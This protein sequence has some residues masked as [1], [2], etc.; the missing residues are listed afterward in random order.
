MVEMP[1]SGARETA[2]TD[3]VAPFLWDDIPDTPDWR[4]RLM[5]PVSAASSRVMGEAVCREVIAGTAAVEGD[6]DRQVA[7]VGAGLFVNGFVSLAE[8]AYVAQAE[9]LS[10]ITVLGGPPELAAL[11]DSE[12]AVEVMAHRHRGKGIFDVTPANHP[13][14]RSVARTASW[15]PPLMLAPALMAPSSTAI[16][17]NALL[18]R[19]ARQKGSRTRYWPAA[20]ILVAVRGR[21]PEREDQNAGRALTRSMAE[22]LLPLAKGLEEPW[23]SRVAA[24]FEARVTPSIAKINADVKAIRKTRRLPANVWTGTGAAY[25]ARLIASEVSRRGGTVTGF[26]HGGVTAISQVLELTSISELMVASRFCVATRPWAQLLEHSKAMTLAAP[27]GGCEIIH[28]DGE[29]T[30]RQACLD[31]S[32]PARRRVVYVGHP[33]RALRQFAIA[34]TSDAIYWDLQSRLAAHL[35]ELSVDLICKPHPEGHFV[36]KRNPIEQIAPT[37]YRRFEEHLPDT[38]V[39]VFDAPTSTTFAE[40]LCTN[41]P[42]VLIERGQYPFNPAIDAH[43]RAR[44]RIVPSHIDDRN[45]IWPDLEALDEAVLGGAD[46]VDPTYFRALLAGMS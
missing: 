46:T 5:W 40:A 21:E 11:R 3:L 44:C 43:I 23:R 28:S 30:F 31:G 19:Y 27:F 16:G 29:P 20:N 4:D 37:S 25:V 45:R 41:R 12:A 34:G 18:R 10:G 42:V 39:F 22:A 26:D 33:Y 24:L 17:H 9:A 13:L 2:G 35:N 7:L 38:D 1:L 32:A 8:A 36:G 15:T 14:L 6:V